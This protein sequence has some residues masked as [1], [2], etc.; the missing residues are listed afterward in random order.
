MAV[1]KVEV[2]GET[3]LDLTQDTVTP[4][5]LLSGVTAHNSAGEQISGAV[6]PVRYDVAQD[7]TSGQKAQARGNID[8][9]PGGFGLGGGSKALTPDDDLND[10]WEAGWYAWDAPPKNAPTVGGSLIPYCSMNV[11]NKGSNYNMHQIARTFEGYEIRRYYDGSQ[12]TWSEWAW[13]NPPMMIG[14]EYCTTEYYMGKPVYTQIKQFDNLAVEQTFYVG[15]NV[16]RY[17]G[18]CQWPYDDIKYWIPGL[19]T[20]QPG[21]T[22]EG[23][24]PNIDF[25]VSYNTAIRLVVKAGSGCIGKSARVQLWYTK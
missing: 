4:E 20:R 6:A 11:L 25:G 21:G 9:A 18:E 3:K 2:N 23:D 15:G 13:A 24:L 12:K 5:N 8:A 1:N 7:L 10:I 14:V 19:P 22:V 17:S 16:I